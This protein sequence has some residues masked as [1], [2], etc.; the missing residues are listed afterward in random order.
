M[1]FPYI[2]QSSDLTI[3]TYG[4]VLAIA[5]LVGRYLYIN[6]ITTSFNRDI[7]C[8]LLIASLLIFGV[9]GAKLMFIIKNVPIG[10]LSDVNTYVS[11]SGF[12]SQGALISAVVVIYLFSRITK[13]DL[14]I[15]LDKAAPAAIVA[16]GIARIGC[17]LSGDDCWGTNSNLPWAMGFPEGVAPTNPHQLVHPVP[18]YEI[19][20]SLFIWLY[21]KSQE[22]VEKRPYYLFFKLILLWGLCRFLVEFVTTNPVKFFAMSGSQLGALVMFIGA[23]AFFLY[24]HFSSDKKKPG[25]VPG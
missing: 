19:I 3:G 11:G 16:Y 2:Y 1:M 22:K 7:N 4:V 9:I 23:S 13:S 21:L 12:S 25:K 24:H 18:L 14:S 17:F 10:S 20:Y 8:E 5:Y 15:L 6:A